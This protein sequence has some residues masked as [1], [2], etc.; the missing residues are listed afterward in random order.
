MKA[1]GGIIEMCKTGCF[2]RARDD[3]GDKQSDGYRELIAR[4]WS[5]V[6][7]CALRGWE[8]A[9]RESGK[10]GDS[11]KTRE[12]ERVCVKMGDEREGGGDRS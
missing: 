7:R 4:P 11:K 6:S 1:I 9:R 5:A 8:T 12:R 2:A 3:R 10:N